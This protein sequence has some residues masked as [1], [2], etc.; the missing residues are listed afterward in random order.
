MHSDEP[1]P[2]LT[3]R[4]IGL[5]IKLH[6]KLGPGLLES[7]WQHCFCWELQHANLEF[8]REV[9]LAVV[10]EDVRLNQG[11]FAGIIVAQTV[12][13]ELKA[14]ERFLPVHEAGTRTYLRLSGCQIAL[15]M[16][17]NAV[18]LK[19]DPRRFIPRP[20]NRSTSSFDHPAP[21]RSRS[22]S[23]AAPPPR[24][25]TAAHRPVRQNHALP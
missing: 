7:V 17:F 9:P 25:R 22:R 12:L 11:Y 21:V 5:A 23:S 2:A 14:T 8:Q 4:I 15:L 13:P 3:E 24:T 20:P 10:N 19:D 18:L 16:N 1:G 6:R